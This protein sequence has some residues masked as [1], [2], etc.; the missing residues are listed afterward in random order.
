[1]SYYNIT[2]NNDVAKVTDDAKGEI[3]TNIG[4]VEV[5]YKINRK[6]SLRLELQGLVIDDDKYGNINDKGNWATVLIEYNVSPHWFFSV[7][8]QWNLPNEKLD[9]VYY[10]SSDSNLDPVRSGVHYPY[11]TA[12]YIHGATRL[13]AGYGRQRAG[14]F[15]VGGVCR[16]VPASNGL[17]ISFTQSF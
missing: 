7:M 5:G 12:G 8:D 6:H 14:L 10:V 9:D 15:C 3:R 13:S 11:I 2:L 4:V 1:L 16:F 17:T